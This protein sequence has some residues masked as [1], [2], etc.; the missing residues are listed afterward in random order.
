MFC[1]FV[2]FLN[3][4][5]RRGIDEF[6]RPYFTTAETRYT[7]LMIAVDKN[8]VRYENVVF[9][10]FI[11]PGTLL[12]HCRSREI[13]AQHNDLYFFRFVFLTVQLLW[14]RRGRSNQPYD[15]F[16]KCCG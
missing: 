6:Y 15:N 9:A 14:K 13:K 4:Q 3:H 1:A 11:S 10:C 7:E 16:S 2:Q 12:C 5:V 8:L